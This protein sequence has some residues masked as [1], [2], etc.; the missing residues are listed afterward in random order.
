MYIN[1]RTQANF[2]CMFSPLL[3]FLAFVLYRL[4]K[5]SLFIQFIFDANSALIFHVDADP[6]LVYFLP[7]STRFKI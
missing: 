2:M 7:I 4:L 3:S 5:A 1:L 6:D